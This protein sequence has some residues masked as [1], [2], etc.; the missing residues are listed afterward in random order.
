MVQRVAGVSKRCSLISRLDYAI[1]FNKLHKF[2]T[3]GRQKCSADIRWPTRASLVTND[4]MEYFCLL[5]PPCEAKETD[6]IRVTIYIPD[7]SKFKP[8]LDLNCSSPFTISRL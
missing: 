2:D 3:H 5:A 8:L 6:S 1:V 4:H 7:M